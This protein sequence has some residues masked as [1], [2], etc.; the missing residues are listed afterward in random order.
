MPAHSQLIDDGAVLVETVT[1]PTVDGRPGDSPLDDVTIHDGFYR[2]I[3]HDGNG[4]E[5]D[6]LSDNSLTMESVPRLTTG[7]DWVFTR[8][9]GPVK[10]GFTIVPK[11]GPNIEVK[12]GGTVDTAG[13]GML[14]T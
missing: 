10:N 3:Q 8:Q 11:A 9:W 14:T 13:F 4:T 1:R 7:A 6:A 5:F 12:L 2:V